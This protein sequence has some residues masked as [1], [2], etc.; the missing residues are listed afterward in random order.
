M[1]KS[2]DVLR[3]RRRVILI[4]LVDDD[5]LVAGALHF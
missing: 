3:R 4:A 5:N 1:A 2:P